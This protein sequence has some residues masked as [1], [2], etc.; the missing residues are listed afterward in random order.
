MKRIPVWTVI[1][2]GW[3][4]VIYQFPSLA[5]ALVY[6]RSA[7]IGG[8]YWRLITGHWAHFSGAHL[9]YNV[10]VLAI[11]GLLIELRGYG[12]LVLLVFFAAALIGIVLLL[13]EPDLARFGGLSGIATAALV[14]LALHGFGDRSWRYPSMLV[15]AI[16]VL[17]I[18]YE[19]VAGV[20]AIAVVSEGAYRL[21]PLSHVGGAIAALLVYLVQKTVSRNVFSA[22]RANCADRANTEQRNRS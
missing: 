10:T 18:G 15:L 14:Y 22:K 17:K 16:L 2:S 7:I 11:T 1:V 5:N 8:E 4:I 9:F 6:E 21:V 20:S 3:A 19:V 12:Q 13:I